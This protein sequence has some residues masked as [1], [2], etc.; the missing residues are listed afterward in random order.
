MQSDGLLSLKYVF[1]KFLIRGFNE[2]FEVYSLL[3]I[4][5]QFCE[6]TVHSVSSSTSASGPRHEEGHSFEN[7]RN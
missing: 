3:F 1:F 4:L 7:K 6:V 2:L 5:W